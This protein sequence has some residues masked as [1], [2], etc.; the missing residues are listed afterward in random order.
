[1]SS[2]EGWADTNYESSTNMTNVVGVEMCEKIVRLKNRGFL[3]FA[4]FQFLFTSAYSQVSKMDD[5]MIAVE[6][7]KFKGK[8]KFLADTSLMY[9]GISS[10]DLLPILNEKMNLAA[11]E[12][13]RFSKE[14]STEKGY[15]EAIRISL[16]RFDD[17]YFRM[18][19]E[20]TER[21]CHYFEE[22]MDIV[23]LESSDGQLNVFRYGFDPS[24]PMGE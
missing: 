17:V 10:P 3:L 1:M 13:A 16:K 7:S 12:F 2:F 6:L 5:S 15:Q 21:V 23:G 24:K 11:D 20:D 9:P 14:N 4:F 19:S 8:D 22:L 18:D